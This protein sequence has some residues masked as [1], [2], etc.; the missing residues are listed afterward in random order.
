MAGQHHIAYFLRPGAAGSIGQVED[1]SDHYDLLAFLSVAIKLKVD[2]LD[3]SWHT[4]LPALGE[5]ATSI[6]AQSSLDI[7]HGLAFKMPAISTTAFGAADTDQGYKEGF[8]TL[9]HEL[10]ALE[11]LR[12]SPYVANLLG[13]TWEVDPESEVAWP[14]FLTERSTLGSLHD[15]ISSE[16]GESVSSTQKLKLCSDVAKACYAM[17]RLGA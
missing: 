1:R 17:H 7:R 14:V 5:G 9:I 15:F 8:K 16:R 2:I 13:I 11:S 6:V 4:G 10:V 12:S 3:E